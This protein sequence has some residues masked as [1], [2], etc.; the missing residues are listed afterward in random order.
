MAHQQNQGVTVSA[1]APFF[2]WK[3]IFRQPAVSE[4]REDVV[5]EKD[6]YKREKDIIL[7]DLAC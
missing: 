5:L 2:V 4:F 6:G 3:R 1:V 7:E